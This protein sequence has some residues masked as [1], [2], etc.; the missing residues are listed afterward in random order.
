MQSST[1]R[2]RSSF[3]VNYPSFLEQLENIEVLIQCLLFLDTGLEKE[4][5]TTTITCADEQR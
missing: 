4:L 1:L 3:K 5:D 2:P